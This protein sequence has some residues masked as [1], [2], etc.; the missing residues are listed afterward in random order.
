MLI[1]VGALQQLRGSD[2]IFF[3][4]HTNIFAGDDDEKKKKLTSH[5]FEIMNTSSKQASINVTKSNWEK[6]ESLNFVWYKQKI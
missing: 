3:F 6:I 2:I 1:E 5:S 4:P